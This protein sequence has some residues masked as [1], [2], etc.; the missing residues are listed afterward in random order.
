TVGGATNLYTLNLTSGAATATGTVTGLNA[1]ETL[2]GIAAASTTTTP[3]QAAG[4]VLAVTETNKLISFNNATPQKLCTST[5]I[6][7]LQ[8]GENVLGID[9]RPADGAVY[10]L[11]S[12]GR[13]YTIDANTAAATVKST[14]SADPA[15]P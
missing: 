2:R 1:G 9:T 4:S 6:G 12:T 8:A 10:A 13:I 3:A 15:A 5:A 11:G 14:L 7:G